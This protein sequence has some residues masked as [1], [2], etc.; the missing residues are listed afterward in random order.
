MAAGAIPVTAFGNQK[1]LLATDVTDGVHT[2]AVS[3]DM[4]D[5]AI[6]LPMFQNRA[7]KFGTIEDAGVHTLCVTTDPADS[8]VLFDGTLDAETVRIGTVLDGEVH[9]LAVTTDTPDS[10]IVVCGF[11]DQTYIIP[12]VLDSGVLTIVVNDTADAAVVFDNWWGVADGKNIMAAAAYDGPVNTVAPE[13]TGTTEVGEILT[14]SDGTW[15]GAATIAYAYQWLRDGAAIDGETADTYTLVEDDLD[16]MIG[17]TVT[18][19][20]WIT[21]ADASADPVGPVTEPP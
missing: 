7:Y 21:S 14:V 16:A 8:A 3:T 10:S 18:G 9:T 2:L 4:P 13:I 5:S 20:N 17:C 6:V 19:T 15:T 1:I 12:A 11:N